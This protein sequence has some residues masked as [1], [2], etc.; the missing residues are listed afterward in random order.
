MAL[1]AGT[2]TGAFSAF[3]LQ[4][5]TTFGETPSTPA[6]TTMP[7]TSF[8]LEYNTTVIEDPSI[9]GDR[10]QHFARNGNVTVGGDVGAVFA[11]AV[12]DQ[13]LEALLLGEWTDDVIKT[14]LIRTSFVLEKK[15]GKNDGSSVFYVYNGQVPKTLKLSVKPN[16]IVEATWTFVGTSAEAVS[17]TS[18]DADGYTAAEEATPF[19]H[20]DGTFSEGGTPVGNFTGIDVTI[21]NGYEGVPVIGSRYAR[22]VIPMRS[23]VTGSFTATF[24]DPT[25]QTKFITE[26]HT[27]LTL[28]LSDGATVPKTLTLS[29]PNVHLDS[30][31]APISGEGVIIQTFNFT[32]LYDVTADSDIVITRSAAPAAP[33]LG[34]PTITGTLTTGSTL[35]AHPVAVTG[36]PTPTVT[37]LWKVDGAAPVGTA[38]NAT[39]VAE[40]GDVTVTVTVTNTE[41]TANATSAASTV[42]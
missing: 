27:D 9:R 23:K 17:E 29:L 34:T 5:E 36:A 41:G 20:L 39:F 37:Y 32:A 28:L 31:T 18:I 42:V 24:E 10:M 38:T 26:E 8:N 30:Y 16:A 15:V 35:T 11:P 25:V 1:A 40:A 19:V 6:L 4:K 33:T 13:L 3:G 14:R 22:D 12:H 7:F 2:G 21:E